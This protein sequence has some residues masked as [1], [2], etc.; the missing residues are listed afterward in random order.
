MILQPSLTK[1]SNIRK[2]QEMILQPSLTKCS[3]IRKWY[4]SLHW[5]LLNLWQ[6]WLFLLISPDPTSHFGGH[7]LGAAKKMLKSFKNCILIGWN[8]TKIQS[9]V[10]AFNSDC[11]IW[12]LS[13]VGDEFFPLGGSRYPGL[14]LFLDTNTFSGKIKRCFFPHTERKHFF[15]FTVDDGNGRWSYVSVVSTKNPKKRSYVAYKMLRQREQSVFMSY[16]RK[17]WAN[18]TKATDV[19]KKL[20]SNTL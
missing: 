1:C 6:I 9:K 10:S 19:L 5:G 3:N 4:Y 17:G 2:Y 11:C 18:S 7:I 14:W 12:H 13:S 15:Q 20:P 16:Q 8:L